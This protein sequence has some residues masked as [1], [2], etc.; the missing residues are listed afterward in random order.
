MKIFFEFF[1]EI[2]IVKFFNENEIVKR[3]YLKTTE[4]LNY[5]FLGVLIINI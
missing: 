1:S 4:H 3:T 2:L 5:S